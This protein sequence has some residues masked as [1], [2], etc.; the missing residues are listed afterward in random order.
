MLQTTGNSEPMWD[1]LWGLKN[2]GQDVECNGVWKSGTP[3]IDVRAEEAWDMQPDANG[4]VVAVIDSG[5]DVN[6]D[7]LMDI[8]WTNHDEDPSNGIDDDNN[9]YV[10]DIHGWNFRNNQADSIPMDHGTHT[11]GTVAATGTN[12]TGIAGVAPGAAIMPAQ[13]I[14]AETGTSTD[15]MEAIEYVVLN[16]ARISNNSWGGGGYHSGLYDVMQAAGTNFD[17]LFVFAAGNDGGA[18]GYP[19]AF[20]LDCIISVAALQPDGALASFSNRGAGVD[21][22]APGWGIVSS[23][24]GNQYVSFNGTSMA[25]PH[26]AGV[27]ALLLARSNGTATASEM[28]HAILSSVRL[29]N[30]LSSTTETGGMLDA[31]AAIT[32][33]DAGPG[34]T[35]VYGLLQHSGSRP[36]NMSTIFEPNGSDWSMCSEH[37]VATLPIPSGGDDLN[38]QDDT[39]AWVELDWDFDYAG[40]TYSSVQVHS[41]GCVTFTNAPWANENPSVENF[42]SAP[43][44][45]PMYTDLDPSTAGS[46]RVTRR[47]DRIAFSWIAVPAYSAWDNQPQNTM[48]LELF[49]DGRIRMT[50]LDVPAFDSQAAM[51]GLGGHAIQDRMVALESEDD[52]DHADPPDNSCSSDVDGDGAVGVTDLIHVLE[53][54][55]SCE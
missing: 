40:H 25:S 23:V 48:Q 35:D 16:G 4:V 39:S 43:R 3:G 26:V 11:A 5:V 44:I 1:E 54:W 18:C 20:D 34:E 24:P 47:S 8:V 14:G 53:S 9:G 30:N 17:H 50:W 46:V 22:A 38:L 27:A 31:A 10:D 13:F 41:N 52:C 33:F 37:G 12:N 45:A 32:A 7:E 51:T 42:S 15:A 21:L 36:Q 6:H 55:G 19:A 28:K 49:Q 2:T 29:L